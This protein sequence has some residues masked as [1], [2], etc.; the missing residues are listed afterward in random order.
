MLGFYIA[1]FALLL[2]FVLCIFTDLSDDVNF[3]IFL[4]I[5]FC[6]AIFTFSI[7]D[8]EKDKVEACHDTYE[9]ISLAEAGLMPPYNENDYAVYTEK[10]IGFYYRTENGLIE[11]KEISDV[12]FRESTEPRYEFIDYDHPEGVER[13]LKVDMFSDAHIIYVPAGATIRPVYLTKEG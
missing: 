11:F 10:G 8:N 7:S 6:G 13:H 12:E 1:G 5:V 2:I 4:A 9:I 3:G